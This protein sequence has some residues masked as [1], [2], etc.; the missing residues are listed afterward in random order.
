MWRFG[1][2]EHE[3]DD[4]AGAAAPRFGGISDSVHYSGSFVEHPQ[5]H[6]GRSPGNIQEGATGAAA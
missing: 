6:G 3:M 2:C 4:V 1:Y 5:S